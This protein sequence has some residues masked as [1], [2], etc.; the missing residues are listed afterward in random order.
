MAARAGKLANITVNV[1]RLPFGWL[2]KLKM[3]HRM[4]HNMGHKG[5][6]VFPNETEII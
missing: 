3:D 1:V 4:G 6:N 5:H 2:E